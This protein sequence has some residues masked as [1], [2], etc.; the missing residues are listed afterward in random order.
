MKVRTCLGGFY[1][2]E[3][4]S[5]AVQGVWNANREPYEFI[6]FD[7]PADLFDRNCAADTKT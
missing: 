4:P 5:I 1:T 6:D 7:S 2:L 3:P